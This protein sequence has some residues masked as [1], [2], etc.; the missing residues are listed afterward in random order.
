MK[1]SCSKNICNIVLLTTVISAGACSTDTRLGRW[2]S[3]RGAFNDAQHLPYAVV[4]NDDSTIASLDIIKESEFDNLLDAFEIDNTSFEDYFFE[5]NTNS[6]LVLHN[7]SVVFERYA[8]GFTRDSIQPTYSVTKSIVS[9]LLDIA[10][11]KGLIDSYDD[12]LS[13]YIDGLSD[14]FDVVTIRDCLNM[15]SGLAFNNREFAGIPVPWNDEIKDYYDPDVRSLV[16]EMTI[17]D[18][19]NTRFTYQN[20]NLVLIGLVLENVTGMNLASYASEVLWK[21]AGMEYN[22]HWSVDSEQHG[23]AKPGAG[24]NATAIDLARLG[25]ALLARPEVIPASS[26]A[27]AMQPCCIQPE[28]TPSA[29]DLEYS[30]D[31]AEH[32]RAVRYSNGWWG[33][34]TEGRFDFYAN[35]HLG[36]FIYLSPEAELVIVRLGSDHG[37]ADDAMFGFHFNRLASA[38]INAN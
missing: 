34:E 30:S 21:P 28:W 10:H 2:A 5:R 18:K 23:F 33:V 11:A 26:A 20:Y 31:F 9:I 25:Y 38:V 13:K 35:G 1:Y 22:A 32:L 6:L 29:D 14:D 27:H 15:V 7:G 17:V 37:D 3:Y 16:D 8:N 24:F 19:P 4:A 12:L 36:Q